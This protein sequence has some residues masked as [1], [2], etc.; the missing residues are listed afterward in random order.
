MHIYYL[1]AVRKKLLHEE[2][3]Q[4]Q[5]KNQSKTNLIMIIDCMEQ[6]MWQMSMACSTLTISGLVLG[7]EKW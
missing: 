6:V 5:N 2:Q 7:D 3:Q 4:Y 1:R